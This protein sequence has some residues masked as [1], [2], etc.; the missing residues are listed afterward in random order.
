MER[1]RG[2]RPGMPCPAGGGEL[3]W[4]VLPRRAG[5]IRR[6][7]QKPSVDLQARQGAISVYGQSVLD[8]GVF[9]FDAQTAV[10][11][12]DG[13]PPPEAETGGQRAE[14][15][16]RPTSDL[17]HVSVPWSGAIG[18]ALKNSG[19]TSIG[20]SP[21]IL[22]RRPTLENYQPPRRNGGRSG[23]MRILRR[24][25]D[26]M[27]HVPC[28]AH[29]VGQCEFLHFGASRNHKQRLTTRFQRS[30]VR[31][32]RSDRLPTYGKCVSDE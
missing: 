32:P 13:R 23:P 20:K 1:R 12:L 18:R 27:H 2:E 7:L 29:V 30:E 16:I 11:L 21:A 9:S 25:Y 8:M 14:V 24:I 10:R 26:L 15:E 17:R 28:R 22:A 6:F 5:R 4:R 19:S 3:S 31:G